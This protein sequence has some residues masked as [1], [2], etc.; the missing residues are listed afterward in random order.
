MAH[1]YRCAAPKL[2]ERGADAGGPPDSWRFGAAMPNG[3]RMSAAQGTG[4][5][6]G[7]REGQAAARP[8]VGRRW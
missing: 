4:P 7:A 1:P 2:H 8:S 6:G 3:S 5:G